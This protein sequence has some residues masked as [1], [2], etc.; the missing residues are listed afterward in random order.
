MTRNLGSTDRL[1]RIIFGFG[2]VAAAIAWNQPYTSCILS[3]IGL[4]ALITGLIGRCPL[5]AVFNISTCQPKSG[6]LH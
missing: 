2:L 6:C 5:L 4:V 3:I 1:A